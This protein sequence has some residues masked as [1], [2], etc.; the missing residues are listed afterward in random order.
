Y[1]LVDPYL[2]QNLHQTKTQII[3]S[4]H[5]P[6]LIKTIQQLPYKHQPYTLPYHTITQIPSLSL[7][8]LKHKSQHQ[9]LKQ[10]HYQ[11][12]PNIKNTYQIPVKV[13]TLPV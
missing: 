11:T 2:L 13:K 6:P 9:L 8:N 3:Q 5:N 7:L 1:V 12:P 4:F 10:I